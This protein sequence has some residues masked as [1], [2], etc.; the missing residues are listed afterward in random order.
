M[1]ERT[2][3]LR[4]LLEGPGPL[5]AVEA[6]SALTAR[7]VEQAGFSVVYCGGS[8]LGGMHYGIPDHGLITV[9]EIVEQARRIASAVSIPL[10][11]DADQGGETSLNVRRTVQAFEEAGVAGI[12]IEAAVNARSDDNFLIIARSDE[13]FNDGSLDEAISRGNAYAEA[14]ADAFMCLMAS[15]TRRD[16]PTEDYTRIVAEVSIPFVDINVPVERAKE[17]GVGIDIFTGPSVFAAAARHREL[18]A[19]IRD[20]GGV[21]W[22]GSMGMTWEE[23]TELML[24]DQWMPVAKA[25]Q[26]SQA[27]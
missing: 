23:Y 27:S 24:D 2:Q 4:E 3:R 12:H 15:R 19:E 17:V 6:Y 10:I 1:S 11:A 13:V 16:V 20:A 7:V 8:A 22:L 9:T 25:W 26:A 21:G 14:G 5:I 18:V